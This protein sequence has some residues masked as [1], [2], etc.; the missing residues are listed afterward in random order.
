M[1]G[2]AGQA[3]AHTNIALAKYWGKSDLLLNLPAV[4]SISLT[5]DSLFTE[6]RV[7]FVQGLRSDVVRLDG[8]AARGKERDRMVRV[9]NRVRKDHRLELFAV[10]E[11]TNHVPTAAGLA[12]SASGFAA[13]AAASV[14]A[15]GGTIRPRQISRLA[16]WSSASAA[17][18]V[19]GGFV[20][21]NAGQPG[22][23]ALCAKP[24]HGP[25]FWD[26]CLVVAKTTQA[27]KK[28]GSTEGM[29]RSRKTSPYYA[30]W[31]NSAGRWT[32]AI[33]SG[34]RNRD[35]AVVGEAM[36]QSTMAFH[37]CTLTSEPWFSYWNGTT[38]DVL[39]KIRDLRDV[40][41]VGVYATMDAGPHVK[42]LCLRRDAKTIQRV[43]ARVPGVESTLVAGPGPD[44][45]VQ[46]IAP[47]HD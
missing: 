21:L 41:G 26:V 2:F 40:R 13:L 38:L 11:S 39:S 9:L 14:C 30:P 25:G 44:M 45:A 42:A 16:R 24:L 5:L 20:Q 32:R 37:A 7:Q 46:R 43:L 10:V 8:K 23:D 27:R 1:T 35:L 19:Y 3:K 18:S 6:T 22:D 29:E 36:E 47:F 15:A 4:P 34:I 28:V 12:S 31:V 17:R 33:R